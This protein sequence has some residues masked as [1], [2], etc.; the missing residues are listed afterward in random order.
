MS[1]LQG[2]HSHCCGMIG[3][4]SPSLPFG[5]CEILEETKIPGLVPLEITITVPMLHN[6]IPM[7]DFTAV[8]LPVKPTSGISGHSIH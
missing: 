8:K 1:V 6:R 3:T 7:I 4:P 5:S 2:Y